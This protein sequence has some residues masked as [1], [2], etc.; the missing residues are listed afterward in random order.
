M[1][2]ILYILIKQ[3]DQMGHQS[4][5]T[6]TRYIVCLSQC[7]KLEA[8]HHLLTYN[9]LSDVKSVTSQRTPRSNHIA[10]PLADVGFGDPT[11]SFVFGTSVVLPLGVPSLPFS[12]VAG[13]ELDR[14]KRFWSPFSKHHAPTMWKFCRYWKEK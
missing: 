12:S 3:N 7:G 6:C 9:F 2:N 10:Y 13:M 1:L 5:S 11:P 8:C 4:R 14:F